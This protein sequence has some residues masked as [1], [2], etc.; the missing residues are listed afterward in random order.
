MPA[1]SWKKIIWDDPKGMRNYHQD[2]LISMDQVQ[3]LGK[4]LDKKEP[5]LFEKMIAKGTR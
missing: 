5:R 3:K 1:P 2:F 4:E